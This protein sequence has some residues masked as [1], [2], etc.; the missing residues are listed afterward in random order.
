MKETLRV[1]TDGSAE[2]VST[3]DL[4]LFMRLSTSDTTENVLLESLEKAAR[5]YCENYTKRP[6][7]PQTFQLFLDDFQDEITLM[8]APL[9]TVVGDVVITYL[10]PTSGE[11]TS[12]S[13]AIFG[14]DVYSEPGRVFLKDGQDWPD[15][16]TQRNAITVQFVAGFP[17][18]TAVT[19]ST[20]TTPDDIKTWIKMRV[21]QQYEFREA[22]QGGS[23]TE[24][25]HSYAD[26]L[27]DRHV[28]IDVRP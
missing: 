18:N 6:C 3:D 23:L 28:L 24:L 21:A 26:G 22:M 4:K 11:S 17:I 19:P 16:Y 8:R 9:S 5:T 12:L 13:T 20:N 14:V 1:I 27:L 25:P 15:H 7:L 10:D 2:P